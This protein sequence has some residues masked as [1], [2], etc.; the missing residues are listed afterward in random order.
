[1][2]KKLRNGTVN[3]NETAIFNYW[4]KNKVFEKSIE[5]KVYIAF[6]ILSGKIYIMN[7]LGTRKSRVLFL[8]LKKEVF[9]V[10]TLCPNYYECPAR[11][12]LYTPT[13]DARKNCNFFNGHRYGN[14]RA[15]TGAQ[16]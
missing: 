7:S 11:T 8:L 16:V 12:A 4:Q 2:F 14:E 10:C 15:R 6:N 9:M 3:E 5:E 1:M 13:I